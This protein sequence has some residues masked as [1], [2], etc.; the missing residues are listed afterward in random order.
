MV[1]IGH[2][3][4]HHAPGPA[5]GR[6][7]R[8]VIGVKVIISLAAFFPRAL[9]TNRVTPGHEMTSQ[10]TLIGPIALLSGACGSVVGRGTML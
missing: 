9:M 1:H 10:H 3:S 8:H 6:G 5:S 4:C 2:M 7:G